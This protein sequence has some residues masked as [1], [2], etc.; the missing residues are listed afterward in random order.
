MN[1]LLYFLGDFY[2][3]ILIN[4]LLF[5][6]FIFYLTISKKVATRKRAIFASVLFSF[7]IFFAVFS[8]FEAYFRYVYDDSDGL[9]FLKVSK[10]WD[11]RHVVY[12]SDFSRDRHFTYEKKEN[13]IRI[14]AI[15]D[16]L[17]FGAGIKNVNDRF[18]NL[19][20][21]KL[22]AAGKNVSVYNFGVPGVDTEEE[23]DMYRNKVKAFNP[24]I[25]VW[26]Y[27]LNDIQ[28]KDKGESARIFQKNSKKSIVITKLSDLS[29]FFDFLYW[30]L[31]SRYANTFG[32]LNSSYLAQYHDEAKFNRH[33]EELNG[34]IDEMHAD[35][36]KVIVIIFPL[37]NLIGDNYPARDIHKKLDETFGLKNVEVIDLLDSLGDKK[38]KE[39]VASRFDAHPNEFVHSI[40]ASKLYNSI[41]TLIN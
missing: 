28:T 33:K 39:L 41:L 17:T 34:I 12:N 4:F 20:E 24:D 11:Q 16:S 31:T 30:R 37:L 23:I 6:V 25:I 40:A 2:Y 18:T 13:E 10:K 5:S 27:Y 36:K 3:Y 21:A 19:L 32:D 38:G 15:G 14:A 35:N 7:F 9:G 22:N 26:Q 29:Y 1:R 8:F